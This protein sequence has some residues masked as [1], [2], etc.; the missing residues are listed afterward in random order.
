MHNRFRLI[1]VLVR[2]TVLTTELYIIA[3][4]AS[5]HLGFLVD[6]AHATRSHN[7][8]GPIFGDQIYARCNSP[9][10]VKLATNWQK[11]AKKLATLGKK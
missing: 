2:G 8:E 4:V 1:H 3:I 11:M 10:L 9:Q 6:N 5:K 7:L